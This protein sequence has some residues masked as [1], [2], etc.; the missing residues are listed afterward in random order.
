MKMKIFPTLLG[1]WY[2]PHNNASFVL[3]NFLSLSLLWITVRLKRVNI[4][5]EKSRFKI[6]YCKHLCSVPCTYISKY[7][8]E[9]N[10]AT[11]FTT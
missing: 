8:L 6:T 11:F 4:E 7:H 5:L 3:D 1:L 2:H 9:Q 10:K